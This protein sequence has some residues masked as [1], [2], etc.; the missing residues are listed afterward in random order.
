MTI[1]N[2]EDYL[3]DWLTSQKH[4]LKASTYD[5]YR[6]IVENHVIPAFGSLRLNQLKRKEIKAWLEAMSCGNKR[7]SNIQ[8]VIRSAL[9]DAV[10]DELLN[11]NI[12]ANFCYQKKDKPKEYDDIDPFTQEEQQAIFAACDQ[13]VAVQ[14][15][16]LFWTGLRTSEFIALD[17]P[18]IDFF[19]KQARI[20]KAM[21]KA[22]K[23]VA[24]VPKTKSGNRRVKLLKPALE[25]LL[26]QKQYTYEK[27]KTVFLN[28][29]T[30]R[31][32]T[33]DSPIRKL[34]E[35]TL[36]AANVRYRRPY[37]TRHTYASMMLSAGENPMWV[38]QQMG[39]HDWTMIAKIYG[40]WMP[41]ADENAGQK[42]EAIFSDNIFSRKDSD[43]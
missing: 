35:K 19:M 31:R 41:S 30:G 25:A 3:T 20:S 15:Q 27:G 18:Q 22:S 36:Q 21:T 28:P 6:T 8:S 38:A 39:H 16:F 14:F 24:E 26:I 34:W 23:G 32:W 43:C 13:S 40:R 5:G 4:R 37:Q 42:A 10:D 17:W 29:A 7:M 33:G 11:N 2:V 9:S 1:T 12:M